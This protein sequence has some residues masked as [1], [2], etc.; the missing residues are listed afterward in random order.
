MARHYLTRRKNVAEKYLKTLK[1]TNRTLRHRRG[2][3]V[4]LFQLRIFLSQV[5]PTDPH[6]ATSLT[7]IKIGGTVQGRLKDQILS[8]IFVSYFFV[9]N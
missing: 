1:K 2:E 4:A 8:L 9:E 6:T 7:I 5:T 3:I